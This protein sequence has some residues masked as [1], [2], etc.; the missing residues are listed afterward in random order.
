VKLDAV[1]RREPWM[2]ATSA[3]GDAVR[4]WNDEHPGADVTLLYSLRS[5][6]GKTVAAALIPSD[7]DDREYVQWGNRWVMPDGT[8]R[9]D[10]LPYASNDCPDPEAF[11]ALRKRARED[12]PGQH[13][14]VRRAVQILHGSME[15]ASEGEQE[16]RS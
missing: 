11:A 5:H 8:E 16:V 10:W 4:K 2:V 6:I 1:E 15:A 14:V 7:P 12:W 13:A 3:V 9:I